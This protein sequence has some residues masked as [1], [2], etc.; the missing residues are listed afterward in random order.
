MGTFK[1]FELLT[2][3]FH[4]FKVCELNGNIFYT[5][6]KRTDLQNI[7]LKMCRKNQNKNLNRYKYLSNYV[8]KLFYRP[9]NCEGFAKSNSHY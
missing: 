8:P 1:R 7:K 6:K 5:S 3:W 4:K 2:I 9:S